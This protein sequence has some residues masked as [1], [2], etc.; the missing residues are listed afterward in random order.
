MRYYILLT[1]YITSCGS[2]I[3]PISG[4]TAIQISNDFDSITQTEM[5]IYMDEVNDLMGKKYLLH[6]NEGVPRVTIQLADLGQ[7][8]AIG[9]IAG[10]ATIFNNH[11]TIEIARFVVESDWLFQAVLTHELGH[12]AGLMHVIDLRQVMS[13]TTISWDQYSGDALERFKH[14]FIGS[15]GASSN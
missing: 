3:P 10:Q 14:D 11:C 2:N 6:E 13:P 15:A 9:E 1:L 8:T 7:M 12:C 4:P 5:W